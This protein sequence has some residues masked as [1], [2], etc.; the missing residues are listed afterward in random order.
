M[1]KE[2]H[3]KEGRAMLY[4][5]WIA[6][7]FMAGVILAQRRRNHRPGL[8]ERSESTD[9][10]AG[11]KYDEVAEHFGCL[12]CMTVRRANGT[13]LHR[14]QQGRYAI[15][16]LFDSASVCLGVEEEKAQT[17]KELHV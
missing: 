10:F 12:P 13:V 4:L 17:R 6:A 14:W 15:A 5:G 3:M 11:L 1:K 2:I 8:R 9:S 7:A 16:L